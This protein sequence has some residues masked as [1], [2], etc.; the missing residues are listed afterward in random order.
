MSA[1]GT[2]K[3][4]WRAAAFQKAA[5]TW[6]FGRLFLAALVTQVLAQLSV[7]GDVTHLDQKAVVALL[8]G[9]AEVVWRQIH[10]TVTAAVVVDPN[11]PSVVPGGGV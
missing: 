3:R 10:P 4:T 11:V 1:A 7:G 9:A 8:I 5:Q 2:L 6:R